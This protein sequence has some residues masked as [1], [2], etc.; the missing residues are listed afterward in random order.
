MT[1]YHNS[2]YETADRNLAE[3]LAYVDYE[4][5]MGIFE[6]AEVQNAHRTIPATF[7]AID[8]PLKQIEWL[9]AE[10][11]RIQELINLKRMALARVAIAKA[12]Q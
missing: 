6:P 5:E 10:N 9:V 12:Q 11:W 8:D 2:E 1:N 3:T 4:G 7:Y